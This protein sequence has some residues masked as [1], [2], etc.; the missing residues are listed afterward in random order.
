MYLGKLKCCLVPTFIFHKGNVIRSSHE[1]SNCFHLKVSTLNLY[2][3]VNFRSVQ[4]FACLTKLILPVS[5]N[6]NDLGV[7]KSSN[8]KLIQGIGDIPT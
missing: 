2:F 7:L 6:H 1:N 3:I 5:P 8:V 4:S